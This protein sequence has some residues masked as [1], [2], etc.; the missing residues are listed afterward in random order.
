MALADEMPVPGALIVPQML[1][2]AF[3]KWKVEPLPSERLTTVIVFDTLPVSET[4]PL[5][6]VSAG[7]FQSWIAP[8][9]MPHH[10]FRLNLN[11]LLLP[12]TVTPA[13]VQIPVG[14]LYGLEIAPIMVGN[15]IASP[16]P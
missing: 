15:W 16:Q 8:V 12:A 6:A 10:V 2:S 1:R 5:S 4:L 3:V 9:K 7:S 13:R 14:G 11:L